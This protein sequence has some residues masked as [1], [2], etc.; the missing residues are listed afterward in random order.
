MMGGGDADNI[1]DH[2][3]THFHLSTKP[4]EH[5]SQTHLLCKLRRQREVWSESV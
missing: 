2:D 5:M 4:P 3:M 1:R